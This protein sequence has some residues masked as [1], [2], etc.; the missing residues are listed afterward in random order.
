MTGDAPGTAPVSLV[1]ARQ[2]GRAART[3][4]VDLASAA[5]SADGV[6][7]L[8]DQVRS[9]IE[10]G[11]NPDSFHLLAGPPGST[12]VAGYAHATQDGAGL[13]GHLV[14]HPDLRRRG[15]GGSLLDDLLARLPGTPV[16]GPT[17]RVW[18][19]GDTAGAQAL[20]ASRGM[21]RARDLIQMRR[22]LD[23]S[24]PE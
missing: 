23:G 6:G 22:P 4:V 20:A 17:L 5:E 14:V 11:A 24:A 9:E 21:R 12:E 7:P 13:S 10:Y 1:R 3:A 15:I 18:A 8:D 2:L 16:T 19:H